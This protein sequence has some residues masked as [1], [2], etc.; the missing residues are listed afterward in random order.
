MS[1]N[2][3]YFQ[4]KYFSKIDEAEKELQDVD[5]IEKSNKIFKEINSKTSLQFNN[6]INIDNKDNNYIMKS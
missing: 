3:K 4:E 1:E 6:L 2:T 5:N